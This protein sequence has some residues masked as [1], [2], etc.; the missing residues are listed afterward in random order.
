M[1]DKLRS[2]ISPNYDKEEGSDIV[3]T[4]FMLPLF[5]ALLFAMI[6]VSTYFQTRTQVQNIT[7][8]G[9]RLVA[10]MGGTSPTIS[11]NKEKFGGSGMNVSTYVY[12]RLTDGS[13]NCAISGCT[14][15]PVVTC[16]PSVAS[17]LGQDA[18]CEV[19]YYYSGV[20]GGIVGWLGFDS[21]TNITIDSRETFK[22][23][24]SW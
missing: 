13:G 12:S 17:R 16:G 1:L 21:I 15:N 2:R 8:D 22:V 23:E 4:L 7:R 6:D 10:L 11:L 14:K 3:V 24:T 18:Y 20:G 9:A 19:K 5:V